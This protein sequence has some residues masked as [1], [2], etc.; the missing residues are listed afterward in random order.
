MMNEPHV[1]LF[2]SHTYILFLSFFLSVYIYIYIYIS[3]IM[4]TIKRAMMYI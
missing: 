2:L 1:S 4:Y 3:L